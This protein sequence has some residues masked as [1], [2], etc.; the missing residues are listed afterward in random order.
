M[1]FNE[2]IGHIEFGT[3]VYG[4]IKRGTF[5]IRIIAG[6]VIGVQFTK[7]D[8]N[9]CL[10]SSEGSVWTTNVALDKEELLDKLQL[11]D[12]NKIHCYIDYPEL[13]KDEK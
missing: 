4:I 10:N 3:P 12:L 5:G 9:Y 7:G 1:A 13:K 2:D 8:I 6:K 11:P